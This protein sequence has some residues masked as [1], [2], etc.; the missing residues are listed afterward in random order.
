[1][2][3]PHVDEL[4]LAIAGGATASEAAR[5][6]LE[7]V[8]LASGAPWAVVHLVDGSYLVGRASLGPDGRVDWAGHASAPL[9]TGTTAEIIVDKRTIVIPDLAARAGVHP[10]PLAR[11][12]RSSAHVPVLL[13]GAVVGTLNAEWTELDAPTP[14][15][16][17][18]LERLAAGLAL[19][20]G[21]LR[22]R[23]ELERRLRAQEAL[24]EAARIVAAVRE[25]FDGTLDA[26]VVEAGRLLGADA[27]ALNLFDRATGELVVRRRNPLAAPDAPAAQVGARFRPRGL[28]LEAIERR[29][30]IFTADYAHDPRVDPPFR[31]QFPVAATMCVPLLAGDELVGV[32]YLDW[33]GR[34]V[35]PPDELALAEAFAGHAAVAVRHARLLA[36]TRRARAELEAVFDAVAQAVLVFALDGRMTHANARA[37]RWLEDLGLGPEVTVA[38][39]RGRPDVESVTGAADSAALIAGALAGELGEAEFLWHSPAGSA[40]RIRAL[41]A[42]VRGPD[43]AVVA[44]VLAGGDV[45]ALHDA[46][47]ERAQLDGAIKT[48]R[49]VAHDLGNTLAVVVG[50]GDMLPPITDRELA[51]LTRAMVDGAARAVVILDQLQ[52][53]TRFAETD[54]GGGPMLDLEAA[55]SPWNRPA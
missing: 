49:R 21:H 20:L 6:A 42:P 32:L 7:A 41:A 44:A 34:H 45:T 24:V 16:V 43:G 2:A 50:Y 26:L 10:A 48:V 54:R 14:A 25:D 28:S 27:A 35:A 13:G 47:A 18:A 46:I 30:A 17:R 3:A 33:C 11:G 36:E 53:I 29:R 1:M 31:A 12:V 52:Q 39:L 55:R 40:H 15:R 8:Q 23:A 9:P 4:A 38:Q 5:G 19:A 22:Q 37:R 51:G